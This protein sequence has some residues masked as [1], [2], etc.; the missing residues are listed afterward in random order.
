MSAIEDPDPSRE[1]V[2]PDRPSDDLEHWL[3]DLRTEV[4][5]DP[6]GWIDKDSA[7]EQPTPGQRGAN[8][9]RPSSS[10]RHRAPD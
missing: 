4:S 9:P 10:G 3:S 7:G 2:G 1:S 5:A 8:A 6:S